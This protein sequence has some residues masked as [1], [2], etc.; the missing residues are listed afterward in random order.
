[1]KMQLNHARAAASD[2]CPVLQLGQEKLSLSLR[3]RHS[4]TVEATYDISDEMVR[5]LELTKWF[6]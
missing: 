5:L 4:K 6:S 1:M 2:R 3:Y